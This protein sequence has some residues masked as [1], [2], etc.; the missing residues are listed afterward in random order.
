[1]FN[2]GLF[3]KCGQDAGGLHS[4]VSS[5]LAGG[6]VAWYARLRVRAIRVTVVSPDFFLRIYSPPLPVLRSFPL[7]FTPPVSTGVT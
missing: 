1:M 4:L 6:R 3:I 2:T 5:S 7:T